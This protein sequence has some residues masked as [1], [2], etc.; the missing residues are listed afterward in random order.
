MTE[1][2]SSAAMRKI[3]REISARDR[4]LAKVIESHPL[5]TVGRNAKP[6]THFEA[7]VDSDGRY[8]YDVSARAFRYLADR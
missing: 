2:I 1:L 7:L 5:C 4:R 8:V 3:V 6:V